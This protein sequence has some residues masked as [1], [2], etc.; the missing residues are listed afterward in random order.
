MKGVFCQVWIYM[1]NIEG[2]GSYVAEIAFFKL[3]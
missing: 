3:K 2:K 1:T